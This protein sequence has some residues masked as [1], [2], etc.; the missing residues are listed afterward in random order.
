MVWF[1]FFISTNMLIQLIVISFFLLLSTGF[2]NQCC[3]NGNFEIFYWYQWIINL[4]IKNPGLNDT[5]I[6]QVPYDLMLPFFWLYCYAN[7]SLQ[8][9]YLV[10]PTHVLAICCYSWWT[11]RHLLKFIL[12]IPT[13]FYWF[14]SLIYC[15]KEVAVLSC[16][17]IP[18]NSTPSKLAIFTTLLPQRIFLNP[19]SLSIFQ[20][21]KELFL[22]VPV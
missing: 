7:V 9:T 11:R 5:H 3:R 8:T 10:N 15:K 4:F 21:V 16:H 14:N 22:I 19:V 6:Y 18:R 12:P 2:M 1:F 17:F 20:I 13:F